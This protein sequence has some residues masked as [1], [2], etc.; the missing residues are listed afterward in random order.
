VVITNYPEG[1]VRDDRFELTA[2]VFLLSNS[3]L[4]SLDFDR[5]NRLALRSR[6]DSV[7]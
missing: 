1:K 3:S 4:L 6:V 5:F 2:L 7:G